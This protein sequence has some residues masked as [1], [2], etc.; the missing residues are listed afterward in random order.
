MP[1][2]TYWA[3]VGLLGTLLLAGCGSGPSTGD[4]RGIAS[5]EGVPIE[6]GKIDFIPA[7]GKG[8]TAGG[9]IKDGKYDVKKV[10]VGN[11][12]VVVSS[13]K[14]VGKKKVYDTPNSPEMPITKEVLP[15][16]YSD[17][18]KS[19]LRFDVQSGQNEKNWDL[20]GK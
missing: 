10:S 4:V 16:K 7:D 15:E 3:A 2:R 12:K 18:L 11:H 17:L 5:Y 13:S 9:V 19:E 1:T 6:D 20:K 14:V 8:P